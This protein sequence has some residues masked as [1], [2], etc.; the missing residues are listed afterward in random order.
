LIGA[1][2][3]TIGVTLIAT[4]RRGLFE[5]MVT[6]FGIFIGPMLIPMLLGLLS[7]RV[8]WRAAAAG[9]AAGLVSGLSFYFY[10]TL[11]LAKQPGID[12]NWLRYDYEAI[13]ILTN[14]SITLLAILLV[15]V[16]ERVSPA[17]RKK[18]DE[19]FVRLATPID[20]SQTH[21]R[22]TGE[23]FSPFYIIGWVTGGTGLLLLIASIVQPA[24]IGR[25]I[26]VGAG[27]TICLLGYG[28]YR[29]HRRV[30]QKQSRLAR[31]DAAAASAE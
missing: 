25:Y 5:V 10:K 26:N 28:F 3:I 2:T 21:A 27:L 12:P 11:V 15:S 9:I 31:E 17:E 6:V 16:I 7:R 14:F 22:L 4:A 18:I 13:S 20:V 1:I 29:L 24:G 23:V 8:T 30:M 19:F